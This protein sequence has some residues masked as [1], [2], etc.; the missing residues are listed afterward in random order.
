ME[1]R[2]ALNATTSVRRF[3]GYGGKRE[4]RSVIRKD[5]C[6]FEDSAGGGLLERARTENVR[7]CFLMRGRVDSPGLVRVSQNTVVK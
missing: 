4:D 5:G 1:S 2:C 6:C 7:A 3:S